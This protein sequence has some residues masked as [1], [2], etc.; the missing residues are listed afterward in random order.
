MLLEEG[1]TAHFQIIVSAEVTELEMANLV[2]LMQ[3]LNL[4]LLAD[5]EARD[6]FLGL[7][8]DRQPVRSPR[9]ASHASLF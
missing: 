5:S 8:L 9:Y 3:C 6:W 7:L 2:Q 1:G 4:S